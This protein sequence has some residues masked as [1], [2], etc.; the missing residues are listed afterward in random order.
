MEVTSSEPSGLAPRTKERFPFFQRPLFD[1]NRPT[2]SKRR[3]RQKKQRAK[4]HQH[5][6]RDLALPAKGM[7]QSSY[8]RSLRK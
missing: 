2:R 8:S 3:Y 1:T 5:R 6:A 7:P 4:H